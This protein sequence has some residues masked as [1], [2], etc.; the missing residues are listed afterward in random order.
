MTFGISEILVENFKRNVRALFKFSGFNFRFLFSN[1][2]FFYEQYF[3]K[4]RQAG[5]GK[6]SSK[7]QAAPSG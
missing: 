6:K 5:N 2:R 3:Y 1:A 4:Q 7:S